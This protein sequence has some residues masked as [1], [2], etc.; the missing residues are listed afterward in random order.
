MGIETQETRVRFSAEGMAEVVAAFRTVSAEGKKSAKETGDAFAGLKGQFADLGKSL[1]AGLGLVAVA[2]GFKNLVKGA[3]D[4]AE[5]LTRLSRQ[6]GL[7]TDTIQAFGR[8]ARETGLSSETANNA[9]EK[10]SVQLG[11]ASIGSKAGATALSDLGLSAKELLKLTPDERLELI[12]RKLA[13]IPEPTRRARDEVA[14]FGKGAL[15]LDQALVKLGTE[16]IGGLIARLKELGLYIDDATREKLLGLKEKLRDIE[17]TSK[18]L[19]LQFITG[20]APALGRITA[21]FT[22]ATGAGEGLQT[23]GLRVGQVLEGIAYTAIAVGK[24]IGAYYAIVGTG[25]STVV[26]AGRLAIH[27]QFSAA[28]QELDSFKTRA[29]SIFRE[30]HDDL[31]ASARGLF[32]D[33][34]D[35]IKAKTAG[36][37]PTT[38]EVTPPDKALEKARFDLIKARLENELH[39]VEAGAKLQL[40]AEKGAYQAGEISL[41]EYYERRAAI[42][43]GEFNKRIETAQKILA[44]EEKIPVDINNQAAA[45][46]KLA[47]EEQLRGQIAD[48]QLQRAAALTVEANSQAEQERTIKERSIAAEEKLLLL[49]GKKIEAA[50]LRLQLALEAQKRELQELGVPS[51]RIAEAQATTQAQGEAHIDYTAATEKA[52]ADLSL[53]ETEKKAIQDDVNS[54]QLNQIAGTQRILDLERQRLAALQADAKAMLDAANASGQATDIAAAQAFNEKVKEIAVSTDLVGQRMKE[55]KA[56]IESSV[57]QALNTFLTEGIKNF[58]NLGQVADQAFKQLFD[59]LVKLAVK[60]EEEKILKSLFGGGGLLGGG[61]GGGGGG[62]ALDLAGF[63]GYA[64]G[65][66]VERRATGGL[67]RGPGTSTSDSIPIWASDKEY[68]VNARAAQSPGVLPLLEAINKGSQVGALASPQFFAGGLV[69]SIGSQQFR[70]ESGRSDRPPFELKVHPDALHLTLRDWFEREI[71]DAAAKR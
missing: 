39:L 2:E 65:G 49:E 31:Q 27:G 8:A 13:G 33:L 21:G 45:V 11:K 28:A 68:I 4:T 46:A 57:G 36:G 59:D 24:S 64:E 26:E 29:A 9:L 6:T 17:D 69:G 51:D 48:L 70:T 40:D 41:K 38:P 37:V 14:L 47:K 66:Q 60:I 63:L 54:G 7:S 32:V 16:G 35:P 44:A 19:G 12:A 10:M 52:K 71:A 5:G 15:E 62:G 23:V 42:I 58:H 22:G 20:L 67:I 1:I 43:N 50:R 30:L 53:L 61:S 18:G 55:L 56:G 34:G 3:L 25:I